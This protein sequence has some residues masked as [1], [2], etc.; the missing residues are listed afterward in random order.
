MRKGREGEK[1]KIVK[2]QRDFPDESS[3]L[4]RLFITL[5]PPLCM[6]QVFAPH[7]LSAYKL[8]SKTIKTLLSNRLSW[9]RKFRCYCLMD[10]YCLDSLDTFV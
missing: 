9:F 7:H 2:N 8:L 1:E 6:Y 4:T 10:Y 3:K 5:Y